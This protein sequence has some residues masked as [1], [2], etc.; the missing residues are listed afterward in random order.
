MS[1]ISK[2]TM[3]GASGGSSSGA[4]SLVYS[5]SAYPFTLS[6][7]SVSLNRDNTK[8]I[9]CFTRKVTS[10]NRYQ[11]YVA[12]IDIDTISEDWG[13][14]IYSGNANGR[15]G[16]TGAVEITS[17]TIFTVGFCNYR[18]NGNST[19]QLFQFL[20]ASNGAEYDAERDTSFTGGIGG[21]QLVIGSSNN[22]YGAGNYDGP[23]GSGDAVAF[24]MN[25][26]SNSLNMQNRQAYGDGRNDEGGSISYMPTSGDTYLGLS[27]LVITPDVSRYAGTMRLSGGAGN[28]D[29]Y[30]NYSSGNTI[31]DLQYTRDVA[32]DDDENCIVWGDNNSDN[33]VAKRRAS[34]GI[35][36]GQTFVTDSEGTLNAK[37]VICDS[38]GNIYALSTRGQDCKLMKFSDVG[39]GS[40]DLEW[41]LKLRV[42]NDT[43]TGSGTMAISESKELLYI[44]LESDDSDGRAVLAGLPLDGSFTG[45]LGDLTVSA[46]TTITASVGDL[47]DVG[48]PG[49]RSLLSG[50]LGAE[51]TLLANDGFTKTLT[52][53]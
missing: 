37:T 33:F 15:I 47:S 7:G 43:G 49:S 6:G 13:K 28:F 14:I 22:A 8:I 41:Q 23:I 9:L 17:G 53:G 5:E 31:N 11:G 36:L 51:T 24:H 39:N 27:R 2:L 16:Y 32:T 1:L 30:R 10:Q 19:D 48:P 20:N 26:S 21:Y 18:T 3:L 52:E 38:S 34:D 40:S 4:F 29:W 45:T 44:Y 12:S 35:D 50:G 46:S 42:L 25:N